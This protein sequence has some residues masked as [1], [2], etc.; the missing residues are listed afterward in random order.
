MRRYL[1]LSIATFLFLVPAVQ[2]QDARSASD[3]RERRR[4]EK[5]AARMEQEDNPAIANY[6]SDDWV[7]VGLRALSKREFLQNVRN[8]GAAHRLEQSS[9][10]PAHAYTNEK[11]HMQV[12]LF[13]DTVVTYVKV[14]RQ[15]P[16]ITEFFHEDD[17]DVFTR[18]A[19]GWHL[20]FSKILPV[21]MRSA[22]E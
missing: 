10:T 8:N 21:P 11:N 22:S 19:G 9:A 4:I 13:G 18:D 5:Q 20:R 3:E 15:S 6:L 1:Q 12:R 16:D 7:C 17:T 2:A 14:Y